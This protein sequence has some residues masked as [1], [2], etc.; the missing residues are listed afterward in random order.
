[1][2]RNVRKWGLKQFLKALPIQSCFVENLNVTFDGDPHVGVSNRL[3]FWTFQEIHNRWNELYTG[4]IEI[5]IISLSSMWDGFS[6]NRSY[7]W[8][9]QETDVIPKPEN[10]Y[11]SPEI[12]R[13]RSEIIFEN[14]VFF[15]FPQKYFLFWMGGSDPQKLVFGK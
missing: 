12:Q 1:M 2:S 8:T 11:G 5:S 7:F 13:N 9:F 15:R 6:V 3:N 4:T 14:F 10:E